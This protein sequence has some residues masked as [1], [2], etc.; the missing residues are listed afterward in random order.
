MENSSKKSFFNKKNIIICISVLLILILLIYL[1][2]FRNPKEKIMSCTMPI[3]NYQYGNI[4]INMKAYYKKNGLI[5]KFDGQFIFSVTDDTMKSNIETFE[6]YLRNYYNN[7]IHGNSISINV[8]R[9][10]YNII[11]NY[12][13]DMDKYEQG[14]YMPLGILSADVDEDVTVNYL[15][16]QVLNMGGSCV[17]E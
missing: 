8:Y 15:E 17:R 12:T 2:F 14:D 5:N 1:L 10:N 7:T 16:E 6:T 3:A 11:V 4:N 9:E 13:I